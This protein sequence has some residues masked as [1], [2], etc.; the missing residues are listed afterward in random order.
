MTSSAASADASARAPREVRLAI[1]ISWLV[2]ALEAADRLWRISTSPSA[3]TFTRL[4]ENWTTAT[5]A[6]ALVVGVFIYFASRRQDWARYALLLA[7]FGGWWLWYVWSRDVFA[8]AWWQQALLV[9]VTAMEIVA[10]LLLFT[11]KGNAW[12]RQP[13]ERQPGAQP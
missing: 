1:A 6:C 7:T 11:G 3:N 13:R 9:A 8:Y 12:F 10:L 4:G 2:L 5:L